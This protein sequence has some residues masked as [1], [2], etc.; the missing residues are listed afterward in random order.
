VHKILLVDDEEMNRDFL[1]RRLQKRGYEVA[2]AVDGR[3]ACARIADLRPD[4]ILMDMMMPNMDGLEATRQLRAAPQTHDIPVIAL[5]AQAM[6]GDRERVIEAGCDDYATK[7]I[8]L[9]ELLE[10]IE[11]LLNKQGRINK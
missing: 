2:T 8:N 11:K 7:P 10:K 3:D 5:T 9:P 4:L 1:G 6:A